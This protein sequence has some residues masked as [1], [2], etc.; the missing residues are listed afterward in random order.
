[1]IWKSLVFIVETGVKARSRLD[2]R[3]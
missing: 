1:M 3:I 2:Y